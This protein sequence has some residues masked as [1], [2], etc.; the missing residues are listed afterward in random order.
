MRTAP[1]RNVGVLKGNDYMDRCGN[2]QGLTKT[3]GN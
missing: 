3:K 2:Q 1:T